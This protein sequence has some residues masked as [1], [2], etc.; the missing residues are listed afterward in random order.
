MAKG[1][2]LPAEKGQLST[3]NVQRSCC[4]QVTGRGWSGQGHEPGEMM[5]PLESQEGSRKNQKH[6]LVRQDQH[7]H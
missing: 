3:G 2:P 1:V 5:T 4:E 6:R 7:L